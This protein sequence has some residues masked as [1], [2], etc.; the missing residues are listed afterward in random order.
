MTDERSDMVTTARRL[1][2]GIEF[3]NVSYAKGVGWFR[4]AF[5]ITTTAL[6]PLLFIFSAAFFYFQSASLSSEVII[7]LAGVV[8]APLLPLLYYLRYK[9]SGFVVADG[10]LFCKEGFLFDRVVRIPLAQISSVKVVREQKFNISGFGHLELSLR[11]GGQRFL[12][13]VS[14]PQKLRDAVKGS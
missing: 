2:P 1:F 11:D 6:F 7:S 10:L 13:D 3:R 5:F 14:D 12:L 4:Y 8:L 9:R